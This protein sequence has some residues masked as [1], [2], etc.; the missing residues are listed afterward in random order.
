MDGLSEEWRRLEQEVR[1]K[2]PDLRLAQKEG[3]P[4]IRGSFPIEFEGEVLDRFSIEISFP[5]GPAALPIIREIGGRIPRIADRHVNATSGD[6]CTD[7]P[8]LTMLRGPYSLVDYL[9]RE[10]R[11]FFLYQLQA[12]T[13][14]Q[15]PH[16]EWK[17]GREGLLQAYGELLGVEGEIA[18]RSFFTALTYKSLKGHIPCPCGS[19]L[20]IRQCTHRDQ[21]ER[22]RERVSP[23]VALSAL[24]RLAN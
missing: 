1:R 8:E 5:N 4:T 20:K 2:Y 19:G 15:W 6:I 7:V 24:R 13:G 9:G 12:E 14:Q 22:L 18:I 10:V 11:N 21:L 23:A 16:G 17:H 3:E